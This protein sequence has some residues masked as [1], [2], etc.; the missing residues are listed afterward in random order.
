MKKLGILLLVMFMVG[1]GSDAEEAVP[2]EEAAP[3]E[4]VTE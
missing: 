3:A 2:V 1:C 4:E